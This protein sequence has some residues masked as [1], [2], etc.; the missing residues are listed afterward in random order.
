MRDTHVYSSGNG[1]QKIINISEKRLIF[2][3]FCE[4]S[5]HKM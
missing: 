3:I 1:I 5:F 4:V 2:S